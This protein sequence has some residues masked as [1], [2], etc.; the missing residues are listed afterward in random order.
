MKCDVSYCFSNIGFY[1]CQHDNGLNAGHWREIA[2]STRHPTSYWK[3]TWV[4]SYSKKDSGFLYIR[5]FVGINI[6]FMHHLSK[7]RTYQLDI[8]TLVD[9]FFDH[10][11]IATTAC[12]SCM[13]FWIIWVYSLPVIVDNAATVKVSSLRFTDNE[14]CWFKSSILHNTFCVFSCSFEIPEAPW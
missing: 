3:F 6:I 10:H 2:W 4:C 11:E 12:V 14:V 9:I 7:T 13:K 5:D 8:F 1:R